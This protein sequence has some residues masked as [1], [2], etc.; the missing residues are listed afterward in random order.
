[1][2]KAELEDIK[3]NPK[4]AVNT[5]IETN[6]RRQTPMKQWSHIY[7]WLINCYIYDCY[8]Y[9]MIESIKD[10]KIRPFYILNKILKL[11]FLNHKSLISQIE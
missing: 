7:D 11:L 5:T 8:A 3:N 9:I 6:K 4:E 10:K 1:M 2:L